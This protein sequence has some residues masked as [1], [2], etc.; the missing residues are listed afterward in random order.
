MLR[1]IKEFF[2]QRLRPRE[3]HG[4][5]AEHALR[6]ATA[7]L[8]FEMTR[9]DDKVAE[10]EREAVR[11]AVQ[12]KFALTDEETA[13]LLSLA[14]QEAEGRTDYYEF[15]SLI[16]DGFPQERKVKV[17]EYLWEVAFADGHLDKYEEQMVRKIADLLYVPHSAFIAAKQR[18]M[19]RMT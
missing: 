15:T 2:E 1:T 7:A 4:E 14:E 10:K 12:T 18:V 8:L 9:M 6:L 11:R 17:V 16:N 3:T 5:A 19:D 13:E